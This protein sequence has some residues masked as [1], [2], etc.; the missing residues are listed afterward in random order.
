MRVVTLYISVIFLAFSEAKVLSLMKDVV[1]NWKSQKNVSNSNVADNSSSEN[2]FDIPNDD[3]DLIN[4][5]LPREVVENKDYMLEEELSAIAE[6]NKSTLLLVN[7][8]FRHGNRTAE[9]MDAIYPNDPYQYIDFYPLGHGQLTNAGKSREFNVGKNLRQ[10]YND[11]LGNFYYPEMIDARSTDTNRTKMSLQLVLAGLF[12]PDENDEFAKQIGYWQPVPYNYLPSNQ[13]SLLLPLA[14]PNWL[15]ETNNLMQ[16]EPIKASL[17]KYEKVFEYL[18]QKTGG[19]ISTFFDVF[20]LYYG[21]RTQKEFG[22]QLPEWTKPVY[23]EILEEMVIRQYYVFVGNYQLRKMFAGA[24]LKKIIHDSRKRLFA[25][26]GR[27]SKKIYLYSAHENNIA[28]ILISLGVYE[29]QI[30]DY[31]SHIIFEFHLVKGIPGFKIFFD[32]WTGEGPKLLQIPGC[33][34][35]CPLLKFIRLNDK[36]LPRDDENACG[37]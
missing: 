22:L 17:K 16:T 18:K 11:F 19:N 30:P 27:L 2:Y 15:V 28:S 5:N 7:V 12:P 26:D 10:R 32:N 35:F 33:G 4:L 13:D 34:T 25:N 29:N 36:V 23:P 24:L 20:L 37:Q 1:N 9:S 3:T 6:K 21:L 14:C 31:G 8:I